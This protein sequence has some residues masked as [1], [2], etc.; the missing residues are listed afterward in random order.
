MGLPLYARVTFGL[1]VGYIYAQLKD[2]H[3]DG[4]QIWIN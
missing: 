3:Y 4:I 1:M 2:P